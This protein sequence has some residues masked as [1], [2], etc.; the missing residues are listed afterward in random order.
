MNG[1]FQLSVKEAARILGVSQH[2]LRAYIRQGVFKRAF[3]FGGRW[4]LDRQEVD[5]FMRGKLK[6]TGCF[7][8]KN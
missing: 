7:K 3:K 1:L 5:N 4:I 2:L 8:K 6:S